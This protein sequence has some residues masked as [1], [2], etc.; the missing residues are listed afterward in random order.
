MIIMHEKYSHHENIVFIAT[1]VCRFNITKRVS[2]QF[3]LYDITSIQ[4]SR[5]GKCQ[6]F[7]RNSVS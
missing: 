5:I 2:Q 1:A 4:W 3:A 7:C 6:L